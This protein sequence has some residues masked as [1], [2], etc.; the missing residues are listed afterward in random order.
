MTRL[1]P[2]GSWRARECSARLRYL[3]SSIYTMAQSPVEIAAPL[4]S[5]A[6]G[7]SG[8]RTKEVRFLIKTHRLRYT[9]PPRR[10]LGWWRC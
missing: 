3:A 9:A 5:T 8:D 10:E 6:R 4:L 1:F 2:N 7:S